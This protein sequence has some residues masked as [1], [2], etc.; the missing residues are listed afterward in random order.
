VHE[1]L[2]ELRACAGTQFDPAVVNAFCDEIASLPHR[3]SRQNTG[4]QAV[5][6]AAEL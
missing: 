5:S 3:Y 4:V 6:R 1:A 2:E